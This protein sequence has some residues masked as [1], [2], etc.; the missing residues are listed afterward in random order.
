[1]KVNVSDYNEVK[2]S[3][4]LELAH[5]GH[6]AVWLSSSFFSPAGMSARSNYS[7]SAATY[8]GRSV[9]KAEIANLSEIIKS[10][11]ERS[12]DLRVSRSA[13]RCNPFFYSS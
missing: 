12:H 5:L 11:S 3:H 6:P 2:V 10:T 13:S 4:K 8:A 1:M 9:R 7:L